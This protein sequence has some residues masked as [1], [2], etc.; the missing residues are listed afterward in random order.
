MGCAC[1]T[2]Q[3]QACVYAVGEMIVNGMPDAGG[4]VCASAGGWYQA[5]RYQAK[6]ML[7]PEIFCL[8]ILVVHDRVGDARR[9]VRIGANNLASGSQKRNR[10][11]PA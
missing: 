8:Q 5:P 4:G 11:L 9:V 2:R 1:A 7:R 6:M 3:A 10:S